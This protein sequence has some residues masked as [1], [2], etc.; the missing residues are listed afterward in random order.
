MLNPNG[1]S[2]CQSLTFNLNNVRNTRAPYTLWQIPVGG[3]STSSQWSSQRSVQQVRYSG[4]TQLYF[5]VIDSDGKSAGASLLYN[6]QASGDSSCLAESV[7]SHG[8]RLS[9][10]ASNLAACESLGLGFA[11]GT[12]AYPSRS[13]TKTEALWCRNSA[14][15]A[16]IV[17]TNS[18]S[19]FPFTL[20]DRDEG[21]HWS[22][23][24]PIGG[25]FTVLGTD[26]ANPPNVAF[27][28]QLLTSSGTNRTECP[29]SG[30]QPRA[31]T[32]LDTES[33]ARDTDGD[34]DSNSSAIVAGGTVGGIVLAVVLATVAYMLWKRK[35]RRRDKVLTGIKV[36]PF[37]ADSFSEP[38]TSEAYATQGNHGSSLPLPGH[39][40]YHPT[41]AYD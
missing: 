39:S 29:P 18:F 31:V 28:S 3:V 13:R 27:T 22:N 11:G 30:S 21:F 7:D 8:L 37:E 33:N 35:Q 20:G 12:P 10:N 1:I 15:Q 41:Q 4:G 34:G 19:F 16:H 14:L 36:Q 25:K 9:V 6:I 24:L 2:Q 23:S 32:G 40:A 26:S 38:Y 5:L 17:P